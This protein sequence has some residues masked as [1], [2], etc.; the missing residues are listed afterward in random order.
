[1]PHQYLL[2]LLLL[3]LFYLVVKLL[4]PLAVNEIPKTLHSF[5]RNLVKHP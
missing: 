3:L 2:L 4:Q 5:L 1:M